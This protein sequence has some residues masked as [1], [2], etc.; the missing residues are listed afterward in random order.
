MVLLLDLHLHWSRFQSLFLLLGT[1]G[2]RVLRFRMF[3][4][5]T[6]TDEA[7]KVISDLALVLDIKM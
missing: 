7:L 6:L 4:C 3:G 5:A 1:A 2:V